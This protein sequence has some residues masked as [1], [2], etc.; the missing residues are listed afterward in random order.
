MIILYNVGG[1]WALR[2]FTVPNMI[3]T[4]GT[5]RYVGT[6]AHIYQKLKNVVENGHS[7]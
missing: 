1:T 6:K 3:A 2:P 4:Q 5:L 7:A